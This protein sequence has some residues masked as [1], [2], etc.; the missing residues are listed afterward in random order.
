[1]KKVGLLVEGSISDQML[2]TKGYKG[3]LTIQSQ[4]NVEAYYKEG[5]NSK[6]I[7]D[8]AI[9]E[10]EGKGINIIFG[11]GQLFAEYFNTIADKYPSIHFVSFNGEATKNNTTTVILEG[12]PIGFFAGMVAGHMTTTNTIA[13][14]AAFESQSEIQGFIDGA[15]YENRN[16]TVKTSY[17]YDWDDQEN[18]LLLLNEQLEQNADIIYSAGNG[19]NIAVIEKLKEKGIYAIGYTSEQSSL[20]NFTVLT[21]TILHIPEIYD[22]I[23]KDFNEGKLLPGSLYVGIKDRFISLGKFS[24]KV[25]KNFTDR[26]QKEISHYIKTGELPEEKNK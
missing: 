16:V 8:R 17:V 1:M 4:Y 20:G 14:L 3:L 12:Y 10:F 15:K 21:S 5:I 25:D 2:G 24:P 11:Q 22:K 18:A 6:A 23:A 19:F 9:K 7:T 26:I 13:S